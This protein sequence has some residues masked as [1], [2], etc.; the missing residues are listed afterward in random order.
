MAN[1]DNEHLANLIKF[2]GNYKGDIKQEIKVEKTVLKSYDK[3]INFFKKRS[4]S[5]DILRKKR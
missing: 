3:C 1:I 4:A 2:K 5:E